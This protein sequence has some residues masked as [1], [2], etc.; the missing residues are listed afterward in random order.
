M[1]KNGIANLA[2]QEVKNRTQQNIDTLEDEDIF[3][4]DI[5]FDLSVSYAVTDNIEV[6]LFGQNLINFTDKN[7]RY[8][9]IMEGGA[10]VDEPTVFGLRSTFKF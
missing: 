2:D 4:L 7:W 6:V 3:E 9:Y 8:V 5:R 1:Y 10:A